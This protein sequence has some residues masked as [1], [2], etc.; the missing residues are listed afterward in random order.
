[1]QGKAGRLMPNFH[2]VQQRI[3]TSPPKSVQGVVLVRG[4][5]S[6]EML[7]LLVVIL[8]LAILVA[9]TM[10]KSAAKASEKVEQ[11]TDTVLGAGD[12]GAKGAAG[13]YCV[14]NAD[15]SSSS[16]DTYSRKCN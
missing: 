14:S 15:C 1:M 9:S 7:L 4:Q 6:V 11:K 10:M 12:T 16:C 8:G 3:L 5:L 2:A 13:D